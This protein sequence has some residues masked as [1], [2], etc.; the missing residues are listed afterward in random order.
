MICKNKYSQIKLEEYNMIPYIGGKSRISSW[1]IGNF[2]KEY[3]EMTYCEVF[4]GG[5]WVL[6]KKE[7]SRVEIYNDL[8]KDL[9]NLFKVIRDNYEEFHHRS[10]WVLHS[11][12]MYNEAR[13]RLKND[14]FLNEIE[15]G[16]NYAI[17]RVQSF[18]GQGG[19][20]YEI[21]ANKESSGKWY[22][23]LRRLE[24]INA[25]LKK[26]QIE[27]LDFEKVIKKYDRP[28]TIFYLDPPY[29]GTEYYYN[30]SGV[31][32][33][34]ED[35][36]RLF[37]VISSI[38]GKFL[39]S[40]YDNPTIKEMWKNYDMITRKTVKSSFGMSGKQKGSKRPEAV[41]M[42]IRNY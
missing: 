8:N 42:L 3:E 34:H 27:C 36:L 29:L 22:P 13:E 26:V 20:G 6:F 10:E 30:Q 19:W 17:N 38:K 40:Y 7:K 16:M 33:K 31:K 4:G 9:V 15:R 39:L 35:H 11:R 23:F 5:G 24:Y 37:E 25:R 28:G 12:E 14:K 2:P 41:E 18:S 21:S 1:V 32:F